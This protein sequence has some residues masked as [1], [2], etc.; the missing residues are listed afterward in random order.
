MEDVYGRTLGEQV[1]DKIRW[2][3]Y[4]D[5]RS[6]VYDSEYTSDTSH[7]D[8]DLPYRMQITYRDGGPSY[9][10]NDYFPHFHYQAGAVL[11]DEDY[12]LLT[13]YWG[14]RDTTLEN[15]ETESDRVDTLIEE[16][17]VDNIRELD[18]D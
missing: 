18:L 15:L 10:V 9:Y 16:G 8:G 17:A 1:R 6:H 14:T 2:E 11:A 7:Q 3:Y 13:E 4:L 12:D 5:E